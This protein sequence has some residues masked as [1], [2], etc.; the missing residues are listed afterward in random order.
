MGI[1]WVK[2]LFSHFW[3]WDRSQLSSLCVRRE[4]KIQ[5]S[6]NK[7]IQFLVKTISCSVPWENL[8]FSFS[9]L[10]NTTMTWV[11]EE[12]KPFSDAGRAQEGQRTQRQ[13]WEKVIVEFTMELKASQK[14]WGKKKSN[15]FKCIH[16]EK[17]PAPR[18]AY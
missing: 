8:H 18:L 17:F 9:A 10:M 2:S 16:L 3:G 15:L 11:F 6:K 5:K 13:D 7:K 4:Q 14:I 12:R 1:S